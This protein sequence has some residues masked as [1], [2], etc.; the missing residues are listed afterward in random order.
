MSL[1]TRSLRDAF[2]RFLTGVT[3]VTT[4]GN[5]QAPSGLTANSFSSVSLEPPLVLFSLATD[6]DCFEQF[7]QSEHFAI[8]ILDSADRIGCIR[9]SRRFY[10][11]V[12]SGRFLASRF[13]QQSFRCPLVT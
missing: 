13:G 10:Y 3:I 2:G 6:A 9:G 5:G 8:N 1:D 11:Q 4:G 12:V 7:E